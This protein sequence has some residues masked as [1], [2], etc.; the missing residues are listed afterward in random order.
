MASQIKD[1]AEWFKARRTKV[2]AWYDDDK[3]KLAFRVTVDGTPFVCAARSPSSSD[4]TSVMKR[5]AGTAQVNDGLIALRI[6]DT[7]HVFDP[8][9]VLYQGNADDPHEDERKARGEEWVYFPVDLGCRFEDYVDGRDEPVRY[10]D[11]DDF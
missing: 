2:E 7:I 5:V 8:V 6:G 4:R 1:F 9:T 3:G 11:V 10:A